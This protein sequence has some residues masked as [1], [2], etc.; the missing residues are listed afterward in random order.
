MTRESKPTGLKDRLGHDVCEN[1]IIDEC[2]FY[3]KE[4]GEVVNC[5]SKLWEVVWRNNEWCIDDHHGICHAVTYSP[6]DTTDYFAKHCTVIGNIFE[7][8]EVFK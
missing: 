5:G 6:V 3:E 4:N 1:D 7:R 8:S 2:M